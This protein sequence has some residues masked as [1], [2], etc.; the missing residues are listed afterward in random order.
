MMVLAAGTVGVRQE[1]MEASTIGL[2][3]DVSRLMF[4]LQVIGDLR[5]V[6]LTYPIS[7]PRNR[8]D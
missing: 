8:L 5:M 2:E 3:E 7:P 4:L 1:L 6:R